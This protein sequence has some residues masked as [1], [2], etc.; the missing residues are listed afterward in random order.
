MLPPVDE[1]GVGA[2]RDVVEE[3]P[4]TNS[5]D[6]DP[7]LHSFEGIECADPVV[8]V[9][10]EI[11]REVV[12]RAERDADERQV[13]LDRRLR[14]LRQRAVAARDPDR[15]GG[16]ASQLGAIVVVAE[17]SRFDSPFPRLVGELFRA[18]ALCAR[19][20]IDEEQD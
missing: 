10:P 8:A 9:E 3:E 1:L 7:P 16:T 18:R 17:D 6:V 19:A 12:P 13:A 2:D 20:R 11:T 15:A 4:V 14:E 5:P